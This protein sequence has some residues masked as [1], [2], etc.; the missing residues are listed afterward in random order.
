M[1][2]NRLAQPQIERMITQVAGS[3]TFP[4][5]VM[6][7]LVQRTDGVPLFVE[8]LTK[9]VLESGMLQDVGGHYELIGTLPALAIP[10]TLQDSLMARLDRLVTAKGIAQLGATIGRETEEWLDVLLWGHQITLQ[11]RPA[12]VRPVAEQGKRHFGVVL[13]WAEWER[14]AERIERLG[15]GVLESPS[16]ELAGTDNEHG[17]FYLHDPSGNVIE[18]KAYRNVQRTLGLAE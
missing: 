18:L 17:K 4:H 10:S 1:T 5:A 2:V 7:Q 12:E 15:V 16:I 8:E 13:P 11:R 14:E 3:K 9:A 6:Q